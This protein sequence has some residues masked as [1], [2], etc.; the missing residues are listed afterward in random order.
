[1]LGDAVGQLVA[2]DPDASVSWLTIGGLAREVGVRVAPTSA[3]TRRTTDPIELSPSSLT[4]PICAD[5]GVCVPTQSSRD[6]S[7]IDTTRTRS[8]YFSPKSAI[9]PSFRARRWP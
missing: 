4:T 5:A 8:P 2:A 1:M 6:H 3:S 7:P 9:A